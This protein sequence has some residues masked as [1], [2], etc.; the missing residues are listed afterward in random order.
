M[1]SGLVRRIFLPSVVL[2]VAAASSAIAQDLRELQKQFKEALD[3]K[4]YMTLAALADQ[5]AGINDKKAVDVLVGGYEAFAKTLEKLWSERQALQL[6]QENF[7][8]I[9]QEAK[10][11]QEEINKNGGRMI[12]GSD[13]HKRYLEHQK[14]NTDYYSLKEQNSA[15]EREIIEVNRAKDSIVNAFAKVTSDEAI[16]E[17]INDLGKSGSWTARAALAEALGRIDH[18]QALSALMD[19]L[20]G[21][22]REAG[23]QVALLDAL[24]NKKPWTAPMVAAVAPHLKSGF[25]QV[26]YA[27]ATA[28]KA[29][30]LPEAIEPLIDAIGRTDGRLQSDIHDALVALTGVDKGFTAESWRG[31][32]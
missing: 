32:F 8:D 21:G 17:M 18:A 5:I 27:A 3:S 12:I 31:W 13:L 22:E 4:N 15:K 30:G 23:I 19:R 14:K 9:H 26:A 24:A 25:W 16:K 28:L 11:L 20:S 2:A 29:S 6:K 7:G 10:Q 1:K